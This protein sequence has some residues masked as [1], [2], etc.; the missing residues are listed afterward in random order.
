MFKTIRHLTSPLIEHDMNEKQSEVE[1]QTELMHH[2]D[3][4]WTAVFNADH[5]AINRF[6][7]ADPNLINVRGAVGECPIHMLFLCGTDKH[8]KIARDLILKFPD[9]VTQIYNKP[10]CI[11][12]LMINN[13]YVYYLEILR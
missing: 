2:G 10:V 1:K 4:I 6:I 5:D 9:I 11:H 13:S 8:F 3:T 12:I 7:D